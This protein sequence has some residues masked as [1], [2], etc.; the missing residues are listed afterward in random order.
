M[1]ICS[2][3]FWPLSSLTSL[4]SPVMPH[5][6][7][8]HQLTL[9]ITSQATLT[10]V[11]RCRY[12]TLQIK[13]KALISFLNWPNSSLYFCGEKNETKIALW[14]FRFIAAV[15]SICRYIFTFFRT[16]RCTA[17]PT[18]N[19]E[20]EVTTRILSLPGAF[21]SHNPKTT[22][23]TERAIKATT[24]HDSKCTIGPDDLIPF[25]HHHENE[26][27]PKKFTIKFNKN[28]FY[29]YLNAMATWCGWI[30]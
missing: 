18:R 17:D 22:N 30:P 4:P 10:A 2:W 14:I 21:T 23:L 1:C 11:W 3:S 24:C 6:P 13:S 7:T 5:R 29:Y 28:N 15:H 20:K 8:L 19:T 25:H 9:L 16:N 27:I 12:N 26:Q